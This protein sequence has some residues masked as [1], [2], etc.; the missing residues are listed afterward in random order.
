MPL[1]DEVQAFK[2]IAVPTNKKQLR[3]F[4]GAIN[5]RYVETQIGCMNSFN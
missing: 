4:I 2:E 3:G 5:Q 1:P